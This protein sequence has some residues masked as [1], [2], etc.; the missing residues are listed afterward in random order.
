MFAT[1]VVGVPSR[2]HVSDGTLVLSYFSNV[3]RTHVCAQYGLRS[4]NHV[5]AFSLGDTTIF[6]RTS[7]GTHPDYE[8]NRHLGTLTSL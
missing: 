3:R 1:A 7:T 2:I 8:G 5:I 4:S 6:H